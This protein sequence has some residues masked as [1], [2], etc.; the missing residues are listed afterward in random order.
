MLLNAFLFPNEFTCPN[1]EAS[2]YDNISRHTFSKCYL[3]TTTYASTVHKL[4]Q[5]H[6]LN[7]PANLSSKNRKTK[8]ST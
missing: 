5:A 2:N 1:A 4:T 6:L 7:F 3:S 8:L